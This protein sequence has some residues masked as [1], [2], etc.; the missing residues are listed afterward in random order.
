MSLMILGTSSHAGKTTTVTAV[1]RCLSNRGLKVAPFKSQN[2]SLNSYITP[3]GK[4]IAISQAVQSFAARISP[5]ADTNPIL[6]KPKGNSTSQII[7]FGEPYKDAA[8][9]STLRTTQRTSI[10]IIIH[11]KEK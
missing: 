6:L 8:L 11:I 5:C 7:L 1:C 10:N 9:T 2:M 4:E 3:D